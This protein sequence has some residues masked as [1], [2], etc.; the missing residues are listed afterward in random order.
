MPVLLK[1][2]VS[3]LKR[4]L[5]IAITLSVT[6]II[7]IILGFVTY[8]RC[9]DTNVVYVNAVNYYEKIALGYVNAFTL[10]IKFFM[11]SFLYVTL[12]FACSITV[13]AL[14]AGYCLLFIRGVVIGGAGCVMLRVFGLDGLFVF[15]FAIFIQGIALTAILAAMLACNLDLMKKN[16]CAKDIKYKLI[17]AGIALVLCLI[18][19]IYGIIIVS[20]VIR[21]IYA[22]F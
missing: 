7:G 17:T 6:C 22:V 14:P 1:C 5:L 20:L 16:N 12:A 2:R 18:V 8:R 3:V 19:A 10:E 13:F 15:F 21:P 9:G 11:T 4:N